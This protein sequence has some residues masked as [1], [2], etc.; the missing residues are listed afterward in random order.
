MCVCIRVC[1][2]LFR[3]DPILCLERSSRVFCQRS[4]CSSCD[5]CEFLY[6]FNA[7]S[8]RVAKLEAGEAGDGDRFGDFDVV[9]CELGAPMFEVGD[10]VGE[11]GFGGVAID[12]VFG[13]D[14]YL[15]VAD[16]Y[17]EATASFEGVGLFD[18]GEVEKVA[19]ELSRSI[20]GVFGDGDLGVMESDDHFVISIKIM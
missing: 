14:V 13:A 15:S 6:H 18:F 4:L 10:F 16:L 2:W 1:L 7:I 19:V 17:P 8:E 9:F 20:F 3:G 11:V 12:V 5:L